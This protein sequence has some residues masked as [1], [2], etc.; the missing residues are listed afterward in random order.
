MPC[1]RV[2]IAEPFGRV[3]RAM[4]AYVQWRNECIAV[5]DAYRGWVAA[6]GAAVAPAFQAY[7]AALDHEQRASELYAALIQPRNG[8][9]NAVVS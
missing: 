1:A 4:D 3:D 6:R 5:G 9:R 2:E 7:A 8:A